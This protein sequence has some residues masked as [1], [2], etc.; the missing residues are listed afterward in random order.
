MKPPN[1]SP[2]RRPAFA[3]LCAGTLLS[4]W[5]A[6]GISQTRAPQK[7]P[8]FYRDVLPLLQDHCQ[9][10]HRA[11]G[12][13]PMAFQT[14]EETRR[15]APAIRVATQ[16]HTMPPW[17]AEKDVD[18][19]SNDVSLTDSQIAMLGAWAD[20]QVPAG[21]PSDAPPP[22]QWADRWTMPTPDLEVKMQPVAIPAD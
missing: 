8:T 15:F 18:K 2:L 10:C 16:N 6:S 22:R 5:T 13:A 19:F 11:G 20:A 1:T 21:N 7:S 3:L 14:Y 4:V 17:F 9:I 12:I